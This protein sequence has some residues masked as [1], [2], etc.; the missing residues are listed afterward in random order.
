MGNPLL[1]TQQGENIVNVTNNFGSITVLQQSLRALYQ[2]RTPTRNF[3]GRS[4]E[5]KQITDALRKGSK[6]KNFTTIIQVRGMPGVG[7]SELATVAAQ[8]AKKYYPDGQLFLEL[9]GT[10]SLPLQIEQVL[11]SVIRAMTGL[12]DKLPDELAELQSLYL[13]LLNGKNILIVADNAA[14]ASHVIPLIPPPGCALI[15]TSRNRFG[16]DE[17]ISIDLTPMPSSDAETLVHKLY[18]ASLQE[19]P[20]LANLCGYLPLALKVSIGILRNEK[21]SISTFLQELGNERTRLARLYDPLNPSLGVYAAIHL[22]YNILNSDEQAMLRRLGVFSSDFSTE[23]VEEITSLAKKELVSLDRRSLVEWDSG[24]QRVRL[25]DL[26]RDY[27]R[28][29]LHENQKEEGVVYLRHAIH[30]YNILYKAT[31]FVL[32]GNM[33]LKQEGLILF[34][35]ERLQIDFGWRWAVSQSPTEIINDLLLDYGN[36]VGFLLD[37]RYEPHQVIPL[38]NAVVETARRTNNQIFMTNAL[39]NLG[40][41]YRAIGDF[42]TAINCH[43]Q[44]L[45]VSQEIKDGRS[46][47][48][49]LLNLGNALADSGDLNRAYYLYDK[50][51]NIFKELGH[52]DGEALSLEN[53]GMAWLERGDT[54]RA[55]YCFEQALY[56]AKKLED[57]HLEGHIFGN[58]GEAY[59]IQ[60]DY[61]LAKNCYSIQLN[62]SRDLNIGSEVARASW[63][64]GLLL[65]GEGKV[66]Q[67][68]EYMCITVDYMRSINHKSLGDYVDTIENIRQRLAT[69]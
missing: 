45:M 51:M 40:K 10:S 3:V 31:A 64:L 44:A 26:I 58:M 18:A 34:D 63:G 67:A 6:N 17:L 33:T 30:Y 21:I 41:C 47:A 9:R 54:F 60:E 49:D 13:S 36:A 52:K 53:M 2:L 39:G 55:L 57:R 19:A 61:G 42:E 24:T 66:N 7:K 16:L 14:D 38:F 28:E 69:N 20:L 43:E 23:S 62:I 46:E 25:H 11:Q 27:A 8:A 56:I 12:V 5:R 48:Q 4:K 50:A 35:Q 68:I 32:I 37:F 22:S 29:Q 15:V 65:A 1:T 59:R